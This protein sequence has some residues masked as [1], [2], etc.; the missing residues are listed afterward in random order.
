LNVEN[1]AEHNIGMNRLVALMLL[2]MHQSRGCLAMFIV[3]CVLG[4]SWVISVRIGLV[5]RD[6]L[7]R[8]E[9]TF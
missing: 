8:I 2:A 1:V 7:F 6:L 5:V 9:W 3:N 4:E